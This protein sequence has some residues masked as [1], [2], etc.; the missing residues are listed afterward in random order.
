MA[1]D[2]FY[3]TVG[4]DP[5]GRGLL[6]IISFGSPQYGDENVTV[7]TLEVVKNM[8]AAKRWYKRMLIEQPWEARN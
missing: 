5:H 4:D 6:A 8:K 2:R 1:E 7:L 3:L